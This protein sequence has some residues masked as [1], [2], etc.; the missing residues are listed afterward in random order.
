MKPL[1]LLALAAILL[2]L[3]SAWI[4]VDEQRYIQVTDGNGGVNW[5][6]H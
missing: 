1:L 4:T 3:V 6:A 5:V 2:I